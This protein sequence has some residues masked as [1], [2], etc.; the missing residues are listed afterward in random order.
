MSTIMSAQG[1][2]L[3]YSNN[4][5]LYDVNMELPKNQITALIRTFRL[6]KIHLLKDTQPYE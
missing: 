5:A 6:R 4:Q 1:L 2:N 3:W